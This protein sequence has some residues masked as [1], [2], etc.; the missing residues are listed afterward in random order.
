M[1]DH[2]EKMNW[3]EERRRAKEMIHLSK[4]IVRLIGWSYFVANLDAKTW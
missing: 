2:Y 4:F 1:R 3:I